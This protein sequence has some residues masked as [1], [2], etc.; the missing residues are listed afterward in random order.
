MTVRRK[1]IHSVLQTYGIGQVRLQ[2]MTG[3]GN[4]LNLLIQTRTGQAVLRCY[5]NPGEVTWNRRRRTRATI[6]YEHAVLAYAA[7]G[8]I[9]C[10]PPAKSRQGQTIITRNG[11]SYALFPFVACQRGTQDMS[12]GLAAADLL[13]RLH[14]L[15]A[16]YDVRE[17]RP[18]VGYMPQ[19][20]SWF[21]ELQDDMGTVDELVDWVRDLEP[22]TDCMR[23]VVRRRQHLEQGLAII[24]TIEADVY[25][26]FP[27]IVNHGDIW[28][29]NLGM[30]DGRI[31]ALFD[32]D[33]C[34][35][36]LRLLDLASLLRTF[37]ITADGSLDE[38]RVAALV[39]GYRERVDIDGD[40]LAL[41]PAYLIAERLSRF[42][43]LIG[44]LRQGTS[45]DL[46]GFAHH[47]ALP[48]AHTIAR[49]DAVCHHL[50]SL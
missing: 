9:P 12:T 43:C 29:A 8:G 36:D 42:F 19:V 34:Q 22:T 7:A 26:R 6:A 20:R 32:F 33:D 25:D 50:R 35:R 11:H 41:I 45:A 18:L 40:E 49:Y 23:Y 5:S 4:N 46:L 37:A 17:Q 27:V 31:K 24:D 14:R 21:H 47:C 44:T 1:D 38:A 16:S 2:Q 28:A 30:A 48:L 39:R 13:G 15:M 10:V 3:G